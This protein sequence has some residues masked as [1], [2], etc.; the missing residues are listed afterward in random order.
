[1]ST[2][3]LH[4]FST[5]G[6]IDKIYFDALSEFQ[7]G[8]PQVVHLL[9]EARVGFR[10]GFTQL[11]SKDSLELTD[12]HRATIR[13]AV[14]DCPAS[15]IVITHGTDTMV[16]TGRVLGKVEGKTIVLTGSLQ[17]ARFQ[18][19]DAEFNVGCAVT[20]AQ[21]LP[22]GVY[23]AMNGQ[24]FPADRCRKDRENMRSSH[25]AHRRIAAS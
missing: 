2:D 18:T 10:Y 6:T 16:E 9:E 23:I 5:G 22:P 20:A 15:R 4:V 11:L 19:S 12:E 21:T 8:D 24:I 25:A 13:E 3:D 14:R 7:V 1:M 17:P